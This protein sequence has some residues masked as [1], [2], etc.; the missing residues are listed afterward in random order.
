[1]IEELGEEVTDTKI[2][3][4]DVDE[5]RDIALQYRVVSIP[6]LLLFKDGEVAATQI[7]ACSKQE[8]LEMLGK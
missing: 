4:L 2:A 7:G 6:T 3:K 5:V 8:L 1:L